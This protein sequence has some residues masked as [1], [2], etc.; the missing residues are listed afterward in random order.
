MVGLVATI[1]PT[2]TYMSR[3]GPTFAILEPI[4]AKQA[5]LPSIS[6]FLAEKRWG[7]WR[8]WFGQSDTHCTFYCNCS[9]GRQGKFGH[10]REYHFIVLD[11][12]IQLE[13]RD[14]GDVRGVRT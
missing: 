14:I 4:T 11:D 7:P 10:A 12:E 9:G 5:M 2:L 8:N 1:T 13:I 3:S 6:Q